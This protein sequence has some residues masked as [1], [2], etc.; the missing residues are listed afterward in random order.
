MVW[1]FYAGITELKQVSIEKVLEKHKFKVPLKQHNIELPSKSLITLVE[2]WKLCKAY[3]RDMITDDFSMEFLL[4]LALS[5]YEAKNDKACKIIAD[6]LYNDKVCRFE[7]PSNIA[8]PHL[9]LAVSYF[10]SHS[11]KTW[12]LRCNAVI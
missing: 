6:H 12:S 2:D 10:I 11:G 7:I 4:L 1:V 3:Y 5:C 8:T 9:L